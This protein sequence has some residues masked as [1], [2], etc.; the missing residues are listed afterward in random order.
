MTY[1]GE[2]ALTDRAMECPV[3]TTSTALRAC[4]E[5]AD[6][7][8]GGDFATRATGGTL[9]NPATALPNNTPA[10]TE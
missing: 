4:A 6:R 7:D 2:N 9:I 3:L 8:K 5:L 1:R 10:T